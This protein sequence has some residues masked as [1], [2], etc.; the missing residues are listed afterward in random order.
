MDWVQKHADQLGSIEEPPLELWVTALND[1]HR[2]LNN[3]EQKG[4][5][6]LGITGVII[7]LT[8]LV[9]GPQGAQP[10]TSLLFGISVTLGFLVLALMHGLRANSISVRLYVNPADYAEVAKTLANRPTS[11]LKPGVVRAIATLAARDQ[12]AE[13]NRF[14]SNAADA[15]LRALRNGLLVL[16]GE[17]FFFIWCR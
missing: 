10:D 17:L 15:S 6:A 16:A 5:I 7:P 12:M 8:V 9:V 3:I 13:V 1:E 4:R 2:R 14:K 11:I